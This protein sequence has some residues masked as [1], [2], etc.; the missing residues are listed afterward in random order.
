[1]KHTLASKNLD[2]TPSIL[3]P[4]IK[5]NEMTNNATSSSESKDYSIYSKDHGGK[6]LGLPV[7]GL[8]VDLLSTTAREHGAKL[9]PYEEATKAEQETEDP[10][11]KGGTD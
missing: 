2:G 4:H 5:Q 11:H 3:N 9:E 1:M 7:H 10:E 6:V 8:Q